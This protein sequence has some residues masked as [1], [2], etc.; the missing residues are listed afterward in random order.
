LSL[1]RDAEEEAQYQ[2]EFKQKQAEAPDDLITS[3]ITFCPPGNDSDSGVTNY[4]YAV[5]FI[6]LIM[7]KPGEL[8]E[9]FGREN[10]DGANF[11]Q[12]K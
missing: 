2:A 12:I 11:K 1:E 10:L 3:S 5:V 4:I 6:E 9:S 8:A 7:A